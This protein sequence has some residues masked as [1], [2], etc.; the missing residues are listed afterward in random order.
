MIALHPGFVLIAFAAVAALTSGR[1]RQVVLVAGSIV[2]LVAWE[3][4]DMLSGFTL[5]LGGMS[6][7]LLR[8]DPLSLFFGLILS[9]V[10]LIGVIYGLHTNDRAEQASTL[11]YA[12]SSLGVV[13]AGDWV[14]SSCS[15]SSWRS[16]PSL[17]SGKEALRAPRAPAIDTSSCTSSAALSCSQV[18]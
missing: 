9:L 17:S 10:T 7:A 13:F 15:G 11:L 8:V 16:H 5:E 18:F 1:A 2:A 4:L 6:L 14:T 12:G 3:G